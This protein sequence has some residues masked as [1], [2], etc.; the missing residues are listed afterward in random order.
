MA[1]APSPE[2][3]VEMVRS[4]SA[5]AWSSVRT[6]FK[7]T[8]AGATVAVVKTHPGAGGRIHRLTLL[9]PEVAER[10]Q[11][12]L[13]ACGLQRLEN[14]GR[15][16]G[17]DTYRIQWDIDDGSGVVTVADPFARRAPAHRVCIRLLERTAKD[18]VGAVAWRDL[19]YPPDQMGSLTADSTPVANVLVDGLEIGERTPVTALPLRVG[20]HKVTFVSGDLRRTY[21][22]QIIA[23]GMTNLDVDLR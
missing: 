4:G 19:F 20:V 9:K 7:V 10:L 8:S 6:T 16:N 5:L 15:G 14:L 3:R 11:R 12:E 18:H 2:F 13:R 1:Q 23:G 17:P 21:E 22:I